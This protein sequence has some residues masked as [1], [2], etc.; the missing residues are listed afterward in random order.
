MHAAA[1]VLA[2][3]FAAVVVLVLPVAQRPAYRRFLRRLR[4]DPAVRP[5]YYLRVIAKDWAAVGLVVAVAALAGR[6]ARSIGVPAYPG[7]ANLTLVAVVL[8][9]TAA[10]LVPALAAMRR[11]GPARD[12][13]TV[14]ALR[15]AIGLVPVTS[16]ERAGFACLCV[17]AGVCEEVVY[18]GF[19]IAYLRWLW[20]AAPWPWLVAATAIPFGL[21]HLYQRAPGVTAA[22][23][24][25][26]LLC[27]VTLAT[28]TLLPA[29]VIHAAVDLHNLAIP[30]ELAARAAAE[31]GLL[32]AG[33][34]EVAAADRPGE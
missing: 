4:A 27:L 20:P 34:A 19:G 15:R 8:V 5:R 32:A 2:S 16:R 13:R 33:R 30:G 25:G 29:I 9:L 23:V 12:E 18:R 28:G 1:A 21:A 17:T 14:R 10:A 11:R 22:T 7:G 26:A 31:E 6:S 24:L 3:A